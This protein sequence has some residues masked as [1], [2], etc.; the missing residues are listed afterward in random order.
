MQHRLMQH[1]LI[2]TSRSVNLFD[3][4]QV[5]LDNWFKNVEMSAFQVFLIDDKSKINEALSLIFLKL[6][7]VWLYSI[8]KVDRQKSAVFGTSLRNCIEMLVNKCLM[9]TP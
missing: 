3:G 2:Q 8:L 9:T 5:N 7:I 6:Q 1:R 4:K